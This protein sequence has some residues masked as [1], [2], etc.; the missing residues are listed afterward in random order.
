MDHKPWFCNHKA[1]YP[2]YS[3]SI[4]SS[5]WFGCTWTSIPSFSFFLVACAPIFFYTYFSQGLRL[6]C[7]APLFLY[8]TTNL[9][10]LSCLD[11]C[12]FSIFYNMKLKPRETKIKLFGLPILENWSKMDYSS[13]LEQRSSIKT[14]T[15]SWILLW[16]SV[17]NMEHCSMHSTTYLAC[18][19]VDH[20]RWLTCCNRRLTPYT[21]WHILAA[22]HPRTLAFLSIAKH[23]L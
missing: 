14:G 16:S 11:R 4:F 23:A 17:A 13:K 10:R 21:C 5:F 6:S 15:P 8:L 19:N 22:C 2:T 18:K 12:S 1:T 20:E 3:P 9:P 7:W